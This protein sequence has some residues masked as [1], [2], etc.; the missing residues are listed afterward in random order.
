MNFRLTPA[1]LFLLIH[2]F[3]EKLI[4]DNKM[5]LVENKTVNSEESEL[6]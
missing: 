4:K 5:M 3:P 2:T 1:N 6:A